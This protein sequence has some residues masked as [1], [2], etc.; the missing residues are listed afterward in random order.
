MVISRGASEI[1]P[2]LQALQLFPA[3]MIVPMMQI[4]WTLFSILSGGIYFQEYKM[5]NAAQGCGYAAGVVV[6]CCAL[7][8]AP[9]AVSGC[10]QLLC[11]QGGGCSLHKPSV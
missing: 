9:E 4:S 2:H 10:C 7:E 6:S 5:L 3:I 11:C 8:I 1:R